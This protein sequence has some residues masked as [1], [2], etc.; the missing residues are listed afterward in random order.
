MVKVSSVSCM[1]ASRDGQRIIAQQSD[2]TSFIHPRIS[3]YFKLLSTSNFISYY[4]KTAI[5]HT[6]ILLLLK[7]IMIDYTTIRLALIIFSYIRSNHDQRSWYIIKRCIIINR[8][9][10]IKFMLVSSARN[11]I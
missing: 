1:R 8:N 7:A 2:K 9:V 11:K 4:T 10:V 5:I 6:R 3:R